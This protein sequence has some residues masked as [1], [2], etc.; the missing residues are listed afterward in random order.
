M[1]HVAYP[2]DPLVVL[3]DGILRLPPASPAARAATAL[4]PPPI[5]A[6]AAAAA[7]ADLMEVV[8]EAQLLPEV[9]LN[10]QRKEAIRAKQAGGITGV[11]RSTGDSAHPAPTSA[12]GIAAAL[13]AAS[14]D[15]RSVPVPVP[16]SIRAAP[17]SGA[18]R[19]SSAQWLASMFGKQARRPEAG[20]AGG[21]LAAGHP[22][23]SYL[24]HHLQRQQPPPPS[25]DS[26]S[27]AALG[28][29]GRPTFHL[30]AS[31]G[32]AAGVG[33]HLTPVDMRPSVTVRGWVGG[34]MPPNNSQS[35]AALAMLV[36]YQCAASNHPPDLRGPRWWPRRMPRSARRPRC[37]AA[38]SWAT[39]AAAPARGE[40]RR[41][42]SRGDWPGRRSGRSLRRERRDPLTDHID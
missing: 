26:S 37:Q 9:P 15:G 4:V 16:G 19:A 32:S 40:R 41:S 12:E 27:K 6:A 8:E 23:P 33:D 21:L 3:N 17:T 11:A 35:T 7:D 42:S 24:Q 13:Q 20:D 14:L 25:T 31:S 30:T 18:P 5:A 10:Q 1:R 36:C 39:S 22:A 34:W 28:G 29:S 38:V 2:K